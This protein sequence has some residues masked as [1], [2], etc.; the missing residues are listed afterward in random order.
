VKSNEVP[1]TKT[2]DN[3]MCSDVQC[4]VC[5]L[6]GLELGSAIRKA[7]QYYRPQA[8]TPDQIPHILM[9]YAVRSMQIKTNA[10]RRAGTSYKRHT[11]YKLK[12]DA[13]SA[14]SYKL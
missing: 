11:N 10:K 7:G 13:L 5:V 4:A 6:H 1:K 8:R 14:I 12:S 2:K 3:E 9:L